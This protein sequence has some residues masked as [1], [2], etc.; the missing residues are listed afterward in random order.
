MFSL[1]DTLLSSFDISPEGY[2]LWMSDT[3]GGVTHLD[4]REDKSR[5]RRYQLSDVKIGT[6][7][8][9]PVNTN[10]LL[11]GSNSRSLM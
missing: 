9:N 7:S 6:V 2:E 1:E 3:D 4:L 10:F 11:T 5:A 8:L